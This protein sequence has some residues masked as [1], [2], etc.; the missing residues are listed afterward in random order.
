MPR[1]N[2]DP[3][4][5]TL[6]TMN[7]FK[8]ISGKFINGGGIFTFLRS[9]V[10]SQIASWIDMG[11]RMIFFA[12]VF[13]QLDDYYRSNLSVLVGAVVGGIV[14]GCINYKFTFHASGQDVRAVVAKYFLVWA[15]SLFFNMFGTTYCA[16]LLSRW[17]FLISLGFSPDAIFA[18]STLTVSLIV[19]LAWNFMMQK[20]FVYKRVER[21]DPGAIKAVNGLTWVFTR[22]K[23]KK[24]NKFK[25]D[26]E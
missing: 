22:T 17:H 1:R 3:N 6:M 23:H 26:K 25:N 10:S 2:D 21:F 12:F 15:V 24:H 13:R 16:M 14:N 20:N 7:S 4:P 5:L 18:T 19:S 9:S 8:K 11:V